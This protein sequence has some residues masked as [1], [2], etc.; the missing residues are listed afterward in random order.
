MTKGIQRREFFKAIAVGGA[1]TA[2]AG[3]TDKTEELIPYLLPPDNVEFVPGIPLEYATTCME[4]PANCGMIV[5]TREAR[6]IK[7]EGNPDH[8]LSRGA[9][10]IRGQASLQTHY[11]PAR[12]TSAR[13]REKDGWKDISWQDAEQQFVAML[14]AAPDKRGIVYIT[15]NAAGSRAGFLDKWLGALGA[16]SKVVL[17]PLG[18]HSIRAANQ[19]TFGRPE[20]PQYRIEAAKL[21]LNFGSDFL[22]TWQ[23][24]VENAQRYTDMHAYDD[25]RKNKG[26]FVH[27]GPHLSLT[28]SNADQWVNVKPGSEAIVALALA[29]GVLER[30]SGGIPAADRARLAKYL[31]RYTFAKAAGDS[32]ADAGALEKL[33][34]EFSAASPGIATDPVLN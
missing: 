6:A 19:R 33:A 3:C 24:P 13:R 29:K 18:D 4:C 12:F 26:K 15:G 22:E 2:V 31:K 7:A 21:L 32:G 8:P 20:V 28:G 16:A 34:Q 27:V 11:N 9:L 14:R 23:N 1:V 30:R 10:C 5:K 17:D 25:R